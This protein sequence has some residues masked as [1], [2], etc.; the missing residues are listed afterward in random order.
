[1]R[2]FIAVLLSVLTMYVFS[3]QTDSISNSF[4]NNYHK[5]N[6]T[7]AYSYDNI[8]QI[9]NYSN[10]WDFDN[11]GIK[12][13]LYFVGTGGAHLYYFLKVILSSD[14]Q[15]QEFN[16]IESDYPILTATDMLNFHKTPIGF[17]VANLDKSLN[18]SIIVRL[19]ESSYYINKKL[20]AKKGIK[21]KNI[22]VSFEHGKTKYG[23]L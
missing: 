6:P 14:N 20:F 7:L 10:N 16:F 8:S 11:D 22:V 1:M 2:F 18:P 5:S 13:D 23:S 15:P 4:E 9:H 19:D 12:D 21:T 3:Q 17:V